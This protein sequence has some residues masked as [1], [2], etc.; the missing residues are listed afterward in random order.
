MQQLNE[1]SAT[2]KLMNFIFKILGVG[3]DHTVEPFDLSKWEVNTFDILGE[4]LMSVYKRY[5]KNL[6]EQGML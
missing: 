2:D 1:N 5:M 3:F 4:R 6:T